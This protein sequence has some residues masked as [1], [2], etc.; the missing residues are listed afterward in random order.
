M[1]EAKVSEVFWSIQGEGLH[2]GMPQLFVRFYGCNTV[3]DF[4]D[5]SQI[6]YES[7][8]KE[9]LLSKILEFKKPYVSISLTG[10]EPLCQ[11]DFIK[12]FLTEYRELFKVP[13]YLETNG[14]LFNA[15]AMVI[16]YVDTVAMDFKLPGSTGRRAFWDEH[17]SFLKIA[18][19][20]NVFI[21]AVITNTT[22]GED[23]LRMR[24]II[25][26]ISKRIPVILQPVT[27]SSEKDRVDAVRLE[28][29]RNILRETLKHVQ[30]IPQVHKLIGVK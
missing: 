22:C 6:F 19:K 26:G 18:A 23:V 17:E 8:T 15:L 20:K 27:P 4:C 7:F 29:F 12:D 14:I 9:R 11:A 10:G 30:I 28:G 24:G 16:D 13:F 3:C 21:K 1:R 2:V 25:T 5:T